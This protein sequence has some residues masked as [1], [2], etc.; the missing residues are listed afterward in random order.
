MVKPIRK[1]LPFLVLNNEFLC[2]ILLPYQPL[3]QTVVANKE[4]IFRNYKRGALIEICSHTESK[5]VIFLCHM[6]RYSHKS[7]P[8]VY[9]C[10]NQHTKKESKCICPEGGVCIRMMYCTPSLPE[11][12]HTNVWHTLY[13]FCILTVCRKS[14]PVQ[15]T[16]QNKCVPNCV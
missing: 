6:L 8:C 11:H 10:I 13:D 4:D 15:Y 1:T 7:P 2:Y 14:S 9:I 12:M 5:Q 3:R 16:S